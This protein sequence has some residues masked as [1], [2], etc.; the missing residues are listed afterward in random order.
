[1]INYVVY[2]EVV[3]RLDEASNLTKILLNGQ[4]DF[5]S[6]TVKYLSKLLDFSQQ[7]QFYFTSD[8]SIAINK[9]L[10]FKPSVSSTGTSRHVARQEK[11]ACTA[12]AL[13]DVINKIKDNIEEDKNTFHKCLNYL[14]QAL[15]TIKNSVDLYQYSDTEQMNVVESIMTSDENYRT[16]RSQIIG[17][18]GMINYR[19]LLAVAIG[20]SN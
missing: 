2:K 16:I 1:M 10:T 12:Q 11:D 18:A 8:I 14:V 7:N 15:N 13:E 17:V 20:N 5:S 19:L 6:Q 4:N 9:I 3:S